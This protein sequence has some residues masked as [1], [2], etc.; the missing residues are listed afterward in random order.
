MLEFVRSEV[1]DQLISST[2]EESSSKTLEDLCSVPENPF[3][4]KASYGWSRRFFKRYGLVLRRISGS[5]RAF[6]AD[7]VVTIRDYL[8]EIRNLAKDFTED[9]IFNF[10]ETSFYMDSV[11]NYT[12]AG[13][14]S[15]KT[16][17][18]TTGNKYLTF[19]K[20]LY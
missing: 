16:Y 2:T 7:T 10:D 15:R 20:C 18:S 6:K 5:G 11:G 8:L 4:F 13:K 19:N 3:Q 12:L 17:A 1:T 14:G 9:E